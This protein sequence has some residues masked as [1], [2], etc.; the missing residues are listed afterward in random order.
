M[1]SINRWSDASSYS[2]LFAIP[3]IIDEIS[4]PSWEYSDRK[5]TVFAFAPKAG[6]T[7]SDSGI[8]FNTN[9]ND[10][11]TGSSKDYSYT[12]NGTYGHWQTLHCIADTSS[13]THAKFYTISINVGGARLDSNWQLCFKNSDEGFIMQPLATAHGYEF[14]TSAGTID[15]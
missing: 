8:N 10:F 14:D 1:M 5:T 3:D 12:Y 11:V 9:N 4:G 15:F 13:L 2:M 7:G 6:G